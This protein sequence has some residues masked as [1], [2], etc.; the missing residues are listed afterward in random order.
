MH[1]GSITGQARCQDLGERAG[2]TLEGGLASRTPQ[3]VGN[4]SENTVQW[5]SREGGTHPKEGFL[6]EISLEI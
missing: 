4:Y 6:K 3:N 5:E 1:L 2:K